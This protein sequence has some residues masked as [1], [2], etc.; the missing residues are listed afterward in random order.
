MKNLYRKSVII[1][2]IVLFLTMCLS[3]MI[4]ANDI[5]E[6]NKDIIFEFST[7]DLKGSNTVQQISISENEFKD[8]KNKLSNMMEELR[9]QTNDEET[10]D[11][12]K[13]YLNVNEYPILS[14]IFSKLFNFDFIGKRK[15]VISQGM[16]PNLNPFKESKTAIIKPITT[17]LYSD[18][19]NLLPIASSTGVLSMN[20]F[21][22][23]TYMGP[24]LGF[25]LKFRGIYVN[26]GQPSSM[27]SYTFFI[28][29]ARYLGG[30]E[31]TPLSSIF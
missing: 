24:Q 28:G 19:N 7:V 3:P 10:I 4:A 26:I 23:K 31:F 8:L 9:V 12:L 17:W 1:T 15:I 20:P 2:V 29:T 22:I 18:A 27:Q 5:K 30:F 6:N 25:M 13:S 14:K 11:L 16:G 21:K